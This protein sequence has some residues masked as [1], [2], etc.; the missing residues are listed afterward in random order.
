MDFTPA[1]LPASSLLRYN[2]IAQRADFFH[3][4]LDKISGLEPPR[5]LALLSS[6]RHSAGGSSG[7]YI[8]GPEPHLR[9]IGDHVSDFEDH[10]SQVRVLP[11]LAVDAELQF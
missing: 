8:A 11:Y 7:Q 9:P 5:R 3:L 1:S 4:G 2:S 6:C 10:I